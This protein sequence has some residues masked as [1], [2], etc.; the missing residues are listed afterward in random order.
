LG[1]LILEGQPSLAVAATAQPDTEH[2][3]ISLIYDAKGIVRRIVPVP[4]ARKQYNHQPA[5]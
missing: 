5:R 1:E 2:P 3:V 4:L